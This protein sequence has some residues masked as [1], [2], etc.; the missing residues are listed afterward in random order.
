MKA[1]PLIASGILVLLV[2]GI[3][4]GVSA[5]SRSQAD[6][7]GGVNETLSRSEVAAFLVNHFR[8]MGEVD[9]DS[10]S[11]LH[12]EGV[13]AYPGKRL[14]PA[15]V[16]VAAKSWRDD[17]KQTKMRIRRLVI[18]GN[19]FVLEYLYASTNIATGK[20]QAVGTV[21]IGELRD[22]KL[23]FWK[24]YLDGRV[25]RTQAKD[26]LPVDDKAEPFPWPDTP[27]SRIP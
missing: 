26:L 20:R 14:T 23:I 3:V 22:G 16:A 12:P 15:Q 2:T 19:V 24:E 21:A 1:T 9:G 5:C 8:A 7:V 6:A 25:S 27:E 13:F 11:D 4:V 10:L 18:E 17:Y